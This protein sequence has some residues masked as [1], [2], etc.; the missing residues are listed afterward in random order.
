MIAVDGDI[1]DGLAHHQRNRRQQSESFFEDQ[2]EDRHLLQFVDIW[3]IVTEG[4]RL[5]RCLLLPLRM[6]S[7]EV[8]SQQWW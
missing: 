3:R 6:F 5:R 7:E 8:G 1:A 2:I 4:P